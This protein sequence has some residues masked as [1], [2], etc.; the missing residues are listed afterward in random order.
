MSTDHIDGEHNADILPLRAKDAGTET[1]V[2]EATGA[3]YTDLSDGR[4]QRKAIIPEHWRTRAA[5]REHVKLAAARHGHAAA[6]HGVRAPG[7]LIL[8]AWWALVG[9]GRTLAAVLAWWHVPDMAKLERQAAADG[10]LSDHLRIHKAGKDTRTA[11]GYILLGCAVV[12]I[13][14]LVIL[15]SAPVWA[16]ILL[17]AV[18]VPLLARAGRPAHKPIVTA[19]TLPATVQ[20]PTQ[21]VITRALG[22]LGIAGIDRWIRDGHQLV[23]PSP[24][25]EDGPGWRAE[26]DLPYGVTAAMVTERREQLASG[27]RRP[28]GAVWPEPVH[29][30]HA[31]RLEL[32]VGRQDVSKAKQSP[33]P[34]LRG[35]QADVFQ[36]IPVR[37]R[38]TR[39]DR[40]G[41]ARVPHLAAG[42]HSAAGQN[43]CGACAGL[44]YRPGPG[45]RDV[46]A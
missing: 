10:L 45:G 12:V 26:V 23:F 40:Q 2:A 29:S 33:W 14:A 43:G 36:E 7:Y 25:R 44:R 17:A 3:A 19:A 6:Y 46:G 24:V 1:K 30:E 20:P 11:R 5:A 38:C 16:W 28:L 37:Q 41:P 21:D 35:G 4:P 18:A 31:G 39:A 32:W 13:A 27:L 15:A 22:S 9:I 8:M 42:E 34:L